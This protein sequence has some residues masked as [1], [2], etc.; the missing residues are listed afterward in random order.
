MKGRKTDVTEPNASP[1]SPWLAVVLSLFCTGLGQVYAGRVA[2]GLTLFLAS[3]LFPLAVAL[4][5]LLPP[6]TPVLV[7]VLALAL[8]VVGLYLFA[9]GDAFFA[10]RAAG[11]EYRP[12]DYNAPSLYALFATVGLVYPAVSLIALRSGVCEA[13]YLPT[14]SMDPSYLAGDRVLANKLVVELKTI[15]R[16]DVV[17]HKAPDRR[18]R[19][20][21]NRVIGLPGDTVEVR[22][23]EVILNGKKL[24]RDRVPLS[25]LSVPHGVGD[26]PVFEESLTGRRYWVRVG[27]GEAA[28]ANYAKREV[29]EGHVFVLGDNRGLARA[30]TEFGPVPIGDVV[31]VVQ[32]VYLPA[33]SWVRFGA[34]AE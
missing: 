28:G 29:P 22:D 12:R 15:Q 24:E 7:L 25:S 10:A 17:A 32:Y 13:Y 23:G 33:D 34:R 14:R 4:L 5:L 20:Y 18:E 16:G 19:N 6:S 9:A 11:P 1:R 31:G 27:K 21:L 26:A 2:R 8:A 3:L 30:S